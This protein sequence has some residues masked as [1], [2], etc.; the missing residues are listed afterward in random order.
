MQLRTLWE[1]WAGQ[2]TVAQLHR[3]LEAY[4]LW[5]F[6]QVLFTT[7]AGDTVDARWISIAREIADAQNAGEVTSRSWGSAVLACTFRGL[8]RTC[9]MSQGKPNL[10]GCPLLL[11]LWCFERFP[12]GRPDVRAHVPYGPEFY[13]DG[14]PLGG[15]TFGSLWTRREVCQLPNFSLYV[16]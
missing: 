14:H 6:G 3:A 11:Q 12:I 7:G 2:L 8:S 10:M 9:V 5:L 1:L 15:P 4:L 13:P 16:L